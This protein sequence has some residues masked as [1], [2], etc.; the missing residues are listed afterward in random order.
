M[1]LN[2]SLQKDLRISFFLSFHSL[3]VK[4]NKMP[5]LIPEIVGTIIISLFLIVF[6]LYL[7]LYNTLRYF[8]IEY[9]R[10]LV[11]IVFSLVVLIISNTLDFLSLFIS[12]ANE[13]LFLYIKRLSLICFIISIYTLLLFSEVFENETFF[14]QQQMAGTILSTIT[15]IS[16]LISTPTEVFWLEEAE[17]YLIIFDSI[18]NLLIT[19]IPVV[20]GVFIVS[21]L[22]KGLRDAWTTQREQLI[23]ILIGMSIILFLPLIFNVSFILLTLPQSTLVDS[24]TKLPVMIGF[25]GIT[26][27]FGGPDEFSHYNRQK[28]DKLMVTNLNGIPLFV[29]DFKENVHYIDETLFSGAVVAITMLMSESIKSPSPIAEVLMKNKYRLLLETKQS[30]IALL[31]TPHGNTF[32]RNSLDRFATAFDMKFTSIITS[33][34]ILDLNLFVKSGTEVLFQNFGISS[35]DL[36]DVLTTLTFEETLT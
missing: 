31:L 5:I 25:I 36:E 22:R 29:H 15:G 13:E 1:I 32:L 26:I 12:F 8:K 16:I 11:L 21:N 7:V 6:G 28:A 14:T 27:S 20:F 34:E 23:I 35:S 3:K 18:S 17:I 30:F 33:G 19:L 24:I 4:N 10:S 9:S 2:H